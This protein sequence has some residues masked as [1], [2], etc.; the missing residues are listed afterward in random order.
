MRVI[1]LRSDTVTVPTSDMRA[2]M[3]QAEVGDD[4]FGEDPTINDLQNMIA[5]MLGKEA[6]LFVSSGTQANQISVNAHTQPGGE[7]ICDYNSHIFN[8]ES[9]APAMLSGVQLHPIHGTNGHPT[10]EQI[11]QALAQ[12]TLSKEET[13]RDDLSDREY[14]MDPFAGQGEKSKNAPRWCSF[15]EC[16]Y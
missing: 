12:V 3:M 7:V 11:A 2:F 15:V 16:C 6:A 10:A 1:D 5:E 13:R 8:Y 9:G 4:V 14:S